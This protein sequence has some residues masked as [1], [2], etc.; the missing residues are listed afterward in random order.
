MGEIRDHLLNQKKFELDFILSK[1]FI[2]RQLPPI[3]WENNLIKIIIGPRRCGKSHFAVRLIAEHS[4]FAY[5]NFDDI[6]LTRITNYEEFLKDLEDVYGKCD[7]FLFDEIQNLPN[8]EDFVG[9]LQRQG[10]NI[11]ITGS[12]SKLT[13]SELTSHL[14]GRYMSILMF[15]F[16]FVENLI[17]QNYTVQELTSTEMEQILEEYM[18]QGGY[19]EPL[20]F[21]VQRFAYLKELFDEILFKDLEIRYSIRKPQLLRDFCYYLISNL[22]QELSYKNV[23]KRLNCSTELLQTYFEYLQKVFLFFAISRYSEKVTQQIIYNKKIYCIDTGYAEVEGFRILGNEDI[24]YHNL[25]AIVL[26]KLALEGKIQ[27]FYWRSTQNWEI[28]FIIKKQT[29]ISQLIQ[30]AYKIDNPKTEEEKFVD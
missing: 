30:V 22:A 8:W 26:H 10:Y 19:P 25:V 28:D 16:S 14:T 3:S 15:P 6:L 20:L 1:K 17:A 21:P 23:A 29:S 4:P 7:T 11:I 27:L 5:A 13:S 9:I 2:E 24:L 12:N 18:I